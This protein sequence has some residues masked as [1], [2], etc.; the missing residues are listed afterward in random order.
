MPK[1]AKV[2]D[3]DGGVWN[4]PE[5]KLLLERIVPEH[6]TMEGY[7]VE[8]AFP[9]IGPRTMILNARKVFYADNGHTTILL[10]IEDATERRKSERALQHLA[11]RQWCLLYCRQFG[12]MAR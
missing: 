12:R 7:E 10:S 2:Y 11:D 9:R 4:L 6:G 1:A 8:R 5:L 3:L